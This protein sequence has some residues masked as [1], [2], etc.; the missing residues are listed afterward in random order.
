ML[1]LS[2]LAF[3]C[4]E[5]VRADDVVSRA[6]VA[7]G[8]PTGWSRE[9]ARHVRTIV[10]FQDPESV[11][12][13]AEQDVLFVS[14]VAG[15][16]SKKDGNGFITRVSAGDMRRHDTFVQG[17]RNGVVLHA[18]KGMTIQGDTLWVTDIDALRGFHRRTGA[19]VATIDLSA[20]RPAMINDVAAGPG[21]TL[22]VTD[23]GIQMVYEGNV[24]TG[25]DRVI[26]I[27]PGHAV[28]VVA[29]GL[30]LR[31]PNG[32]AWDSAGGRWLVVAFDPF[33]GNV[34]TFAPRDS[35]PRL[36]HRAAGRLDGVEPLADGSILFASWADS[37][38]HHWKAGRVVRLIRAVPEPADIGV[39]TRRRRVLIP[40]AVLGQVQV[41][42]VP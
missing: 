10:G 12:Y 38:I 17:G 4:R 35:A 37:S 31:Q 25:P 33:A 26:E 21:G 16:G 27:G 13:D 7:D 19:P 36:L 30:H 15:F 8:V 40:L 18:P 6:T 1:L 41:W 34:M 42:T 22:R 29:E 14:N 5:P 39:D 32:V 28:R 20:L 24:H 3:A 23:T 9:G 11:R 2:C